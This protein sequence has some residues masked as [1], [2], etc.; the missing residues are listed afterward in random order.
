MCSN[1]VAAYL[2]VASSVSGMMCI[3]MEDMIT[4]QQA[5]ADFSAN[6]VETRRNQ[7]MISQKPHSGPGYTIITPNSVKKQA[8]QQ[9]QEFSL[10]CVRGKKKNG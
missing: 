9:K 5:K 4:C 10:S 8:N 3:P 6:F 7:A 1:L 2:I